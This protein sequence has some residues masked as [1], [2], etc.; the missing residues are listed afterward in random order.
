MSILKKFFKVVK[1]I[2]VRPSRRRKKASKKKTVSAKKQ[3][4]ALKVRKGSEKTPARA[5]NFSV[6]SRR[7]KLPSASPKKHSPIVKKIEPLSLRMGE[8]THYFDRIK[9]CVIRIDQGVIKKG[10]HLLIKG[11]KGQ[12]V[13]KVISMQIENE[14][15]SSAQE[16]QLIGLKVTKP[17]SVGDEVFILLRSSNGSMLELRSNHS[18]RSRILLRSSASLKLRSN[19]SEALAK[20]DTSRSSANAKKNKKK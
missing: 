11:N 7:K 2:F 12:L 18:S 19:R 14:D 6:S 1:K 17:V 13:Q 8:V 3:G 16:G 5:R 9:V 10:D 15:V 20:E 4:L